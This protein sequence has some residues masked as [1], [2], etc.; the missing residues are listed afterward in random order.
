MEFIRHGLTKLGVFAANPLAFLAL[1]LYG[2]A[3]I[4][5]S[6]STFEWHAVATLATFMMTLLI[7]RA[8]HRDTQAI[9]AKLDELLHAHQAASNALTHIDKEEPEDIEQARKA[10]RQDD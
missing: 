1:A 7:Q 10:A 4:I 9:H 3:W 5:A 8:T 6:P 2:A